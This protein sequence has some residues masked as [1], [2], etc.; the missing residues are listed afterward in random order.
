VRACVAR[1]LQCLSF[2]VDD[3]VLTQKLHDFPYS[4]PNAALFADLCRLLLSLDVFARTIKKGRDGVDRDQDVSIP[5][6]ALTFL[7]HETDKLVE[8]LEKPVKIT[9]ARSID[10]IS[11][12]FS[13]KDLDTSSASAKESDFKR[14]GNGVSNGESKREVSDNNHCDEKLYDSEID[15]DNPKGDEPDGSKQASNISLTITAA[16]RLSITITLTV[17]AYERGLHCERDL[18]V[19]GAAGRLGDCEEAMLQLSMLACNSD[20]ATDMLLCID[21]ETFDKPARRGGAV[22]EHKR[23]RGSEQESERICEMRQSLLAD[24]LCRILSRLLIRIKTCDAND[25]AAVLTPTLVS[26]EVSLTSV[27]LRFHASYDSFL[28]FSEDCTHE[29]LRGS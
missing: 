22:R 7:A 26:Y 23:E 2:H 25:R 18:P 21:K 6:V 3:P 12:C 14:I 10:E 4:D 19:V 27:I 16:L 11:I 15:S 1:Q 8:G 13:V 29:S 24:S 28:F 5:R 17:G 20:C 9:G